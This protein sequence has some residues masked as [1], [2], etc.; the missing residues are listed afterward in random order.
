MQVAGKHKKIISKWGKSDYNTTAAGSSHNQTS[1]W[2][3]R[4]ASNNRAG[5]WNNNNILSVETFNPVEISRTGEK[6]RNKSMINTREF[7]K[8]KGQ[9]FM[10]RN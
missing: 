3:P 6:F 2:S 1:Y 9:R 5:T 8:D 7:S 4:T 10:Q